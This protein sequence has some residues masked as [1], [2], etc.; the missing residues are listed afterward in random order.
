MSN[1]LAAAFYFLGNT[2]D[3]SKQVG[4]V[5]HIQVFATAHAAKKWRE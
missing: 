5:D 3:T 2:I 4:D 1:R